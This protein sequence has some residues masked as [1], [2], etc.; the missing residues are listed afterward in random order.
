MDLEF[1]AMYTLARTSRWLMVNRERTREQLARLM[2]QR[3]AAQAR[4]ARAKR[5]RGSRRV[6]FRTRLRRALGRGR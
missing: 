1:D 5:R 4:R 2:E 3:D 6:P